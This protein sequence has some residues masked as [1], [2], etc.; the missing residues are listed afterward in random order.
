VGMS[1]TLKR[2]L[3]I[4]LI[5]LAVPSQAVASPTLDWKPCDGGFECATAKVPLD[6]SRP[7]GRMIELALVRARA[8]DPATK[9]GSVFSH[10]GGPGGSGVDQVRNAPAPAIAAI[11]RRFDLIGFDA[12]GAAHSRPRI[13]CQVDQERAGVFAQ[14]F[15]RP[16]TLDVP[17]LVERTEQYLRRC[18]ELQGDLLEHMSS[19]DVARDLDLLR[20]AVGDERLN[21]IGHSYGSLVGA[22][23]AS[24]FPGRARALVLDSPMDAE[25]WA[26]E[27]FEA[28]REQTAGLEHGLDRFFAATGVT[29]AEFD[30]LLA[31][32]DA[33]PLGSLDGDDL[34]VA[35]MSITSPTEWPGFAEA[36]AAAQ[37]GDGGPL[38]AMTDVFYGGVLFNSDLAVATQALDQRYPRRVG[39]FLRA[40][41]HAAALFDHFALNS[42]YTELSYGLLPVSERDA[43]H[44]PFRNSHKSGPALVIGTKHDPWTPYVW[45]K[46]LTADLRNARLLT[47]DG[48]GHGA[49]TSLNPCI[50][51]HVLGYLEAGVLPPE[52]TTCEQGPPF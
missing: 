36:I 1:P 2:L 18:L 21:Y 3:L 13:D 32:L 45:A 19:A 22:T 35:A 25:T 47:Y 33:Q 7:H 23:Y 8:A 43:F 9:I 44:G 40:G 38:R 49:I 12:R 50:V 29:E 26:N 46:R 48:D 17:V 28:I 52:G 20:A 16:E 14:P 6:H 42:G 39:P 31:R 4:A 10:P 37:Q 30:D 11:T 15:V 34:R 41:R 5:G 51:G 24:L 27:P